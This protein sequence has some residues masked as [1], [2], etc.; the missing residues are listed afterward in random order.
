LGYMGGDF[1][2]PSSHWDATVLRE[3]PMAT[4]LMECATSL[5][6]ERVA[7]PLGWVTHLSYNAAL[8]GLILNCVVL[9]IYR[10]Y[11]ADL[12]IGDKGKPNHFP[13]LID[14]PLKVFWPEGK[15]SI[16]ANSKEEADFL[17]GVI[18]S[19]GQ[20]PIPDAM[21]VDHTQAV[22]QVISKVFDSAWLLHAK[23]KWACARSKPWWDADCDQAKASA[24]TSDLPAD[25]MAFKKA[26][27]KAKCKHFDEHIEEIAHTNL[28]PWDLMDW[29]GPHKTLPVEAILYQGVPCTSP[30]Q[31]W[32][33]LHSTF[34]SAL[35]R[36][37][38][39]SVLG[40]KW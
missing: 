9:P 8:C 21:S 7:L 4:R 24:M 16:K 3:H 2:C 13:L 11:T 18:I 10:G 1:N 38:D 19:L 5:N 26:T 23:A 27:C 20:I 6:M 36:P 31:L 17:G 12:T 22:A 30:D 25:W 15:M 39:L 29:V 40:D 35:D 33:T 37:I 28:R 14:V 34:N 32:N